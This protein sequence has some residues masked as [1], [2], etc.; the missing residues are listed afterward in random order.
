MYSQPSS[1]RHCI[2]RSDAFV[3]TTYAFLVTKLKSTGSY[4]N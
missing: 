3:M 2:N 1:S 4:L